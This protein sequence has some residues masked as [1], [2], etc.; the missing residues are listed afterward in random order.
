MDAHDGIIGVH[1]LT[2]TWLFFIRWV[3]CG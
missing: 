2:T 3:C 1:R